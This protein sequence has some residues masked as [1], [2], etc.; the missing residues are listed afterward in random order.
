[1]IWN[2]Y[3]ETA[4]RE[5][6]RLIQNERLVRMVERIY[7]NVPFYRNKLQERGIE[8]GD[9][10]SVDQLKDLPLQ[11]RMISE[12][13][14]RLAC[15][16]YRNVKLLDCMLQV[17]QRKTYCYWLYSQRLAD[18]ERSCSSFTDNGWCWQN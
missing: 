1:M 16:Q 8:P 6:L 10:T 18:L 14:I 9:I 11:Q 4:D 7:Y 15:L 5:R 17:A 2:E 3:I 12:I 13:I